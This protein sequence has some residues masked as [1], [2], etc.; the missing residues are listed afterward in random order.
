MFLIQSNYYSYSQ[1]GPESKM[2]KE[3][4]KISRANKRTSKSPDAAMVVGGRRSSANTPSGRKIQVPVVDDQTPP[5]PPPRGYLESLGDE[6]SKARRGSNSQQ[7]KFYKGGA[8]P[9]NSSY[10]INV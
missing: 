8:R 7:Q 4:R 10:Q 2:S 6:D 3:D 9:R 1:S 5:A